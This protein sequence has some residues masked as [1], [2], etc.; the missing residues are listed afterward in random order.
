LRS[1]SLSHVSCSTEPQPPF[2]HT[3]FQFRRN[4]KFPLARVVLD[5]K[6]VRFATDLAIFYIGLA[7]ASRLIHRRLV[8]LAASGAL[9]SGLHVTILGWTRR[10]TGRVL[11][12]LVEDRRPS[13][14][15]L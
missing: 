4:H 6:Q 14:K 2:R 12:P 9:E 10:Q 5:A 8:G 7:A 15:P 3:L 13:R 11:R 1:S